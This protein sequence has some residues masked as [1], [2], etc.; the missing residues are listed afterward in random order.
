MASYKPGQLPGEVSRCSQ[1]IS[2][3][4]LRT[5]HIYVKICRYTFGKLRLK[6]RSGEKKGKKATRNVNG[7]QGE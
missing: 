6:I 2:I 4:V 3:H 7:I 5:A 1:K